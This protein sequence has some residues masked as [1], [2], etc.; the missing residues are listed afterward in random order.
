MKTVKFIG[1]ALMIVLMCINFVSCSSDDN[2][3]GNYKE[4]IVGIWLTPDDE[5]SIIFYDNGTGVSLEE[6]E[7]EGLNFSWTI[8]HSTLAV[9]FEDGYSNQ[10]VI[11]ELTNNM[12]VL[13]A[14]DAESGE[15]LTETFKKKK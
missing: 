13:S 4:L 1:T 11:K 8:S 15:I 14:Y 12:M 10:M 9:T 7:N 6:G 2:E 3:M 5:N